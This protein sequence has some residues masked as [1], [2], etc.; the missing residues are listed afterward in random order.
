[1]QSFKSKPVSKAESPPTSL[2]SPSAWSKKPTSSETVTKPF[3]HQEK[4]LK[5]G[6]GTDV[7]FDCSDPGTGK[8][9]VRIKAFER[10]RKHKSKCALVLAPKSLLRSV[11]FNDFKKFAPSLTVAVSTAGK[12][13]VVFAQDADVYV[14]NIDAVK[15]LAKQNKAFF[16]RF[17][18]LIIDEC[19]P[20]GTLV[21][22]PGGPR[23]IE[24][25][26]I[27]DTVNTSAGPLPITNT[28]VSQSNLLVRLD[29]E[30]GKTI[31]CTENHPIAT[32]LGWRNAGDCY[33]LLAVQ[34]N[35]HQY[36]QSG[37]ALLQPSVFEKSL[38]GEHASGGFSDTNSESVEGA[39]R[40]DSLEQGHPLQNRDESKAKFGAHNL[41]T[42]T[43]DIGGQRENEPP[44][45]NGSRDVAENMAAAASDQHQTAEG[46]RIPI[47]LQTRLCEHKTEENSRDRREFA[48]IAETLRCEE[49]FISGVTRV[50]R[51]SRIEQRDRVNVYNLQVDGPHDYS[52]E[53]T[54]VHNCTAYKHHT[55]QRSKAALK[56]SK[57]FKYRSCMTG[58][59]NSNTICDVWHQVM[60]L[61]G[62]KRLGSSF[63]GFRNSVCT[64]KQIG[65]NANA[66]QWT[67]KDG[68]EEAVFGLLS[69]IV[70]RHKFEDCVDIPENHQYN[71][72]YFLSPT[73]RKSY[74]EMQ[75][76]ALL[77][78]YGPLEKR[79]AARMRGKP[80]TPI[81]TVSAIHAGVMA[82]KLCQI[83]SGAVYESPDK[84]HLIDPSRYEMILDLIEERKHSLT[85][86]LWKHQRDLL[87]SE[88]DR[89]G[90]TYALI[91]GST[92][93]N[94]RNDI[95]A[96]YQRGAYQTIFAHPK[97]AAHG[98]TLTKG[99]ATIWAS[100]TYDLEIFKQGSKRQ[101][102]MGQT[103]KT[104]TIIVTADDTI[105]QS[106]F[107]KMLVKDARMT[108]LLDLFSTL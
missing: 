96:R 16:D 60:L 46:Q 13:E 33:D 59:P 102:R 104:E 3:K 11:W 69:D 81:A 47:Q 2:K 71:V 74:D 85:F 1:L 19:F 48:Y 90:I 22:T 63:Y 101:H 30:N 44:R 103:Q 27:G 35:V 78:L 21:D 53:G 89:R 83:A 12:H 88:A 6:L 8:T 56:I 31:Y 23:N 49:R 14:T 92:K 64:P 80:P 86:F 24:S 98:L 52:V 106:V 94:E 97:S 62:G 57:F 45:A 15:W 17:D 107:D 93:E 9:Y 28:F 68:A 84:Y 108:N 58:T 26:T 75:E 41:G 72:P 5:H 32:N 87:L 67:D 38:L 51:V 95:V 50:V 42:Q 66:V 100:P 25:L 29:L 43:D 39:Q 54:L 36:T 40:K 10:R 18:E 65:F 34:L 55:S 76:T 73:H 7:V 105:E 79:V 61:D 91:D 20:S 99:T 77:Q 70:I 4:S 37:A 82:Q